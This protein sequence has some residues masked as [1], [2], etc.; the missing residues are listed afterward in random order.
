[1]VLRQKIFTV[2]FVSEKVLFVSVK[3]MFELAQLKM[4]ESVHVPL[5]TKKVFIVSVV[6]FDSGDH[7]QI[8]SVK[9]I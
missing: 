2:P 9:D 8:G 6:S 4:F 3:N 7:V 1:M 5:V